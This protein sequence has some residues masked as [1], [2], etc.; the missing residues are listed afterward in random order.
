MCRRNGRRLLESPACRGAHII[1]RYS[2]LRGR[3]AGNSVKSNLRAAGVG[4]V[5]V[6]LLARVARRLDIFV[7]APCGE[8]LRTA[9]AQ[10]RQ[11]KRVLDAPIRNWSQSW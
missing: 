6:N 10:G 5:T 4:C 1:S 7:Y 11:L 2:G 8:T 9:I 3:Y